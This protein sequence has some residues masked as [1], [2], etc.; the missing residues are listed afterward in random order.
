M[1]AI[2]QYNSSGDEQDAD[3]LHPSA[4]TL[5]QNTSTADPS[6]HPTVQGRV[7][8]FPHVPG[9]FAVH[10]FINVPTPTPCLPPLEHL[11]QHIK[12]SFPDFSPIESLDTDTISSLDNTPPPLLA[13]ASYHVSLSR[14]LPIRLPLADP[15]LT[16]LRNTLHQIKRFT[17]RIHPIL[18]AFVNDDKTR[19]FL[20]LKVSAQPVLAVQLLLSQKNKNAMPEEAAAGESTND[21]LLQAIN[22]VSDA[23]EEEELQRFYNF[24]RPHISLGW[25]LGDQFDALSAAVSRV[26][27]GDSNSELVALLDTL[28]EMQWEIEPD[29]I[30]CKVGQV[31]HSIWKS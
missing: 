6:L 2:A 1:E 24:P 13:Q 18:E 14:T 11:L 28:G 19:T 30:W 31:N 25:L 5:H 27:G 7:R 3:Q 12:Q 26:E 22:A 10:V 21:P 23:F 20:A 16:S 8:S 9:N 17:L 4:P 29:V 15:L